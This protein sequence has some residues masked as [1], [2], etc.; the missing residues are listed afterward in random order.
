MD[1]LISVLEFLC[2]KLE[3]INWVLIGSL[4]LMIQGINIDTNDIDILTDKE[5]FASISTILREFKQQRNNKDSS[6]FKSNLN[7]FLVKNIKIEVMSDLKYKNNNGKWIKLFN[8]SDKRFIEFNGTK[9]PVIPLKKAY[10][11]YIK[12]GKIKTAE[13]IREFTKSKTIS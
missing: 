12:T 10:E 3:S 2:K 9:Y 7:T 1:N 11:A 13:K 5:G 4:N 8:L 6:N